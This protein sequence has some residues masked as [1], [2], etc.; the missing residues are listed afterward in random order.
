MLS[1]AHQLANEANPCAD[2]VVRELLAKT[3]RA[4][5]MN[6]TEFRGGRFA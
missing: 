3:R 6:R 2:P 1:K 5:A 4:Y